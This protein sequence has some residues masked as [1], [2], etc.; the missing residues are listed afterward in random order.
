MQASINENRLDLEVIEPVIGHARPASALVWGQDHSLA[1][2]KFSLLAHRLRRAKAKKPIQTV[3]ITSAIA[4]EGKSTVALNLAGI[5][6]RH[7]SRTLLIDTDL[8]VPDIHKMLGFDSL[9]GLGEVL[10]GHISLD[11]ALRRV[12]PVGFYLLA[13]GARVG[14]PVPLLEGPAFRGILKQARES[15]E[16]IILD[17]PPLNP[18]ADAQCVA[19]LSDGILLVVRWGITPRKELEQALAVLDES[20]LLGIVL[21]TFDDPQDLY[22]YSYYNK[23]GSAPDLPSSSALIDLNDHSGSGRPSPNQ[24][25]TS[26]SK[27]G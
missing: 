8:R 17:S 26:T 15:F 22:Y 19:P 23:S 24:S 5:L 16:W 20:Q 21:N 3:L 13:A 7:G 1:A 4:A 12:D 27:R 11:R 14:N 18:L 25:E 9:T 2:E 10:S 6:A